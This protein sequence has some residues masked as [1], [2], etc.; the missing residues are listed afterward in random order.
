MLKNK[1]HKGFT[2]AEVLI[3]LGIIGVIAA[4]TI[5]TLINKTTNKELETA[6]KKNYS[7]VQNAYKKAYYDN[8][9]TPPN[10]DD[11]TDIDEFFS[12]FKISSA[13]AP[14]GYFIKNFDKTLDMANDLYATFYFS[15]STYRTSYI[16]ADG[17]LIGIFSY[18]GSNGAGDVLVDTNG[19]KGPNRVGYD[20]FMYTNKNVVNTTILSPVG[21]FWQTPPEYIDPRFCTPI[22]LGGP[23]ANNGSGAYC[24][25]YAILNTC[26]W[27]N[28]KG[29]WENL[30]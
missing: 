22:S 15:N 8:G 26:P 13:T 5:P 10:F 12:N 2:L 6:F 27:D 11:K 25:Y 9:N 17:S 28:T 14:Q 4:L 29:Y 23:G 16:L 1:L 21:L 3:T 24:T 19:T 18:N 30:P 20:V 7:I